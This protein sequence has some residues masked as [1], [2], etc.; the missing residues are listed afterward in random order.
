[1]EFVVKRYLELAEQK[2]AQSRKESNQAVLDVDD[3]DNIQTPEGILMRYVSTPTFY[4]V[5]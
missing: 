2:T 1:L 4:S 5:T 3:L